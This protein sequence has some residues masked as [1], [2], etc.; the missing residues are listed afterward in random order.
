MSNYYT[1]AWLDEN[2][3]PFYIGKGK[4]RRAWQR[5]ANLVDITLPKSNVLILKKNLTEEEAFI[6]ERYMIFVLGRKDL[7]TGSLVNKTS[8]GQGWDLAWTAE[9]RKAVSDFHS[10]RKRS[11][12]TCLKMSNAHK[13]KKITKDHLEKLEQGKL[14]K[15]QKQITLV[16]TQTHET[17]SFQSLKEAGLYIGAHPCNVTRLDKGKIKTLKK[18]KK[19]A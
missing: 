15:V 3:K 8:G 9:R 10:G 2:K 1:Y 5:H 17:K 6:H 14:K 7:R 13:G 16:N 12:E 18:W 19:I 11:K 4:G